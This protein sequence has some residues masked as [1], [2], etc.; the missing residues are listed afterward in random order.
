LLAVIAVVGGGG[1]AVIAACG[2]H[3][4]SSSTRTAS[5][6]GTA[7]SADNG[8]ATALAPATVARKGVRLV[9]IGK[10]DQPVYLAAAP[11]D[12]HRVF[13]VQKTGQIIVVVNGHARSRPFLN[14]TS[15][16]T[17]TGE[18][19]GLLGLVFAPD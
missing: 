1:G 4:S 12:P 10:F 9:Q 16:V 14:I 6:T 19:Q 17:S 18:E 15:L 7:S 3:S 8:T 5:D 13:V 2:S 11:G